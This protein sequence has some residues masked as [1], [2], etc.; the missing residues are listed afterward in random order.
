MIQSNLHMKRHGALLVFSILV[1]GCASSAPKANIAANANPNDEV[2]KLRNDIANG[3]SNDYA[4]LDNQD[5]TESKE[6]LKKAEDKLRDNQNQQDVLDEVSSARGYYERAE[7]MA[8]ERRSHIDTVLE[9]RNQAITA[10]A[11]QYP[12]SKKLLDSVDSD[13]RSLAESSDIPSSDK[14]IKIQKRYGEVQL[15]ALEAQ[16]L[17]NAKATIEAAEA[18]RGKTFAPKTLNQAKVDYANAKMSISMNRTSSAAYMPTVKQANMS[19]DTLARVMEMSRKNEKNF[20]EDEAV[21][22]VMQDRAIHSLDNT[23]QI[24]ETQKAALQNKVAA[25]NET[26]NS[27]Q[28]DLNSTQQDLKASNKKVAMQKALATAQGEFTAKEAEVYQK[29]NSLLIRLKTIGFASGSATIPAKSDDLLNKVQGIVQGLN[30]ESIV[31]QGHTD[32]VGSSATN[33]KL[34]QK[35]AEQVATYFEK[36]GV[37]KDMV[38]TEGYGDQKPL[39]SNKT[40]AG[41][42]ENRRIDI[43]VTPSD[44]QL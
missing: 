39:S 34:S 17:G 35:R 18:G 16:Q 12:Q 1:A 20:N 14:V 8:S 44:A 26:L 31:I 22:I 23:V 32:S 21:R 38:K 33:E 13:A 40:A 27:T 11:A 3:E 30:P 9:S 37:N 7:K 43:I 5:F 6:H 24:Q 10:G 36:N 4:V 41:R 42:A 19:A 2:S 15:T 25:Q 28:Q 29:D